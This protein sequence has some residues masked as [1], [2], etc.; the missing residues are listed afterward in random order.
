MNPH[1][2]YENGLVTIASTKLQYKY[3]FIGFHK[4]KKHNYNIQHDSIAGLK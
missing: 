1:N 2:P 3:K 4:W